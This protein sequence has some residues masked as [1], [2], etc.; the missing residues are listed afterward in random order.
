MR[1]KKHSDNKEYQ[2]VKSSEMYDLVEFLECKDSLEIISDCECEEFYIGRSF[3][4][5]GD[6]ETGKQFKESV[7]NQLK[8]VF[9]DIKCRT[10]DITIS[11]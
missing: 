3:D 11:S 7:E 2:K 6:N 10:L 1:K 9:D 4:K 5:I 8:K